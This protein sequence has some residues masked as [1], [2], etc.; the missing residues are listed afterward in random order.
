M[1]D[2][3]WSSP[4]VRLDNGYLAVVVDLARPRVTGLRLDPSGRGRYSPNQLATSFPRPDGRPYP[5]NGALTQYVD[6]A[7]RLHSSADARGATVADAER[8]PTTGMLVGANPYSRLTALTLTGIV[9]GGKRETWHLAL[10]DGV[11]ELTWRIDEEWTAATEITDCRTPVFWFA[12]RDD[13]GEPFHFQFLRRDMTHT[14]PYDNAV[15]TLV[16]GGSHVSRAVVDEPGGWVVAKTYARVDADLRLTASDRLQRAAVLNWWSFLGQTRL[17]ADGT[18]L[19]VESGS[20]HTTTFSLRL[21]D[22]R[23]TGTVLDLAPAGRGSAAARRLFGTHVNCAMVASTRDGFLGNEPDGYHATM[24]SWMYSR[25]LLFASDAGPVSPRAAWSALDLMRAQLV[26]IAGATTAEGLVTSGYAAATALDT[27]PSFALSLADYATVTGDRAFAAGLLD[28]V[29]RALTAAL[30]AAD[31]TGGLLSVPD[32]GPGTAGDVQPDHVIDYWDWLRRTGP[33][34]YPNLLFHEALER[35]AELERWTGDPDRAD[36]FTAAAATLRR[37]ILDTF[38]DEANG[39]LAESAG[40]NHLYTAVQYLAVTSGLLDAA[41]AERVMDAIDRR[42]AELPTGAVATPTNLYDASAMMPPFTPPADEVVAFGHTM[43]G[44]SLLSWA[45]F[46]IG[47]LVRTGRLRQAGE[48]L[49][50]VFDRFDATA[51]I[52]GVNYWDR[53]GRPDRARLEPFL[54]DVGLVATAVPRW[55]LGVRPALDRLDL[56]PCHTGGVRLRHLGRPVAVRIDA[57]TRGDR[58]IGLDAATP[59]RLL[60]RG[61]PLAGEP[62]VV[63]GVERRTDAAGFLS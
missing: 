54:S 11:P 44:G 57:W 59:V 3:S 13:W 6:R 38:W 40:A 49:D 34:A 43:N 42:L 21:Q 16:S 17:A 5:D 18:P 41:R 28:P 58:R 45:Y 32:I 4:T 26:N 9:Y 50:A 35:H 22:P 19:R 10:A 48:R 63:D 14:D 31:A 7:G 24:V 36:T 47:A 39:C 46:E 51:L 61:Q 12:Q 8:I 27:A 30:G 37:R 53:R 56:D 33:V 55:F 60:H 62:V 25:A 29:R 23:A 52:E 20:R 2:F 15:A 1:P